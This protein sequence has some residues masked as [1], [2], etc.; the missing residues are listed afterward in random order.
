MVV[1][2]E[3]WK[4][5]LKMPVQRCP[6]GRTILWEDSLVHRILHS[7]AGAGRQRKMVGS[8]KRQIETPSSLV[9]SSL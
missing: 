6:K 7:E 4:A 1:V 3:A 8:P 5:P 2:L 9:P